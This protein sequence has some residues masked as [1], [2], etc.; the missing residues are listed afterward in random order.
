MKIKKLVKI[1][2]KTQGRLDATSKHLHPTLYNHF[3]SPSSCSPSSL[4]PSIRSPTFSPP[5]P[6]LQRLFHPP[7]LSRRRFHH[8]FFSC[9]LLLEWVSFQ[10]M[11]FMC[12]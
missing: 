11:H 12:Q 10:F 7:S 2:G 8:P 9:N 1:K 3:S 5:L 4:S 6:L